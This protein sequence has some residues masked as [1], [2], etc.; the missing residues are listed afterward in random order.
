MNECE[1]PEVLGAR[2]GERCAT[3]YLRQGHA[4][5]DFDR[6]L[7]LTG[8]PDGHVS[9]AGDVAVSEEEGRECLWRRGNTPESHIHPEFSDKH[10]VVT[11]S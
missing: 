1:S 3:E 8:G 7:Q 9:E 10:T 2:L 6:L 4:T 5:D 11:E